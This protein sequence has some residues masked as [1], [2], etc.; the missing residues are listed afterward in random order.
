MKTFILFVALC[1]SGFTHAEMTIVNNP[2]EY[3]NEQSKLFALGD[4]NDS[5][6]WQGCSYNESGD[7]SFLKI[8]CDGTREILVHGGHMQ[9]V[10]FTCEFIFQSRQSRSLNKQFSV[11]KADCQ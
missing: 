10:N 1:F 8:D 4:S 5:S 7:D 11:L 6:G 2:M 3:A 9:K